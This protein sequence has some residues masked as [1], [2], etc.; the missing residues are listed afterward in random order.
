[1]YTGPRWA[2][3][4]YSLTIEDDKSEFDIVPS[5]NRCSMRTKK[6]TYAYNLKGDLYKLL[7]ELYQQLYPEHKLPDNI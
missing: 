7:E 5:G 4:E 6:D 3:W 1:V 2:G